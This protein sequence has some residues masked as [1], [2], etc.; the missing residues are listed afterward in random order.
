MQ[1][2]YWHVTD[3]EDKAD[4]TGMYSERMK[5]RGPLVRG[6]AFEFHSSA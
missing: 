6:C 2:K 5:C 3:T 1:I 4:Y